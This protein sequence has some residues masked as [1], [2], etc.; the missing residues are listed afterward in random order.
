MQLEL[1]Q[2]YLSITTFPT[3]EVPQLTII[4]GLNGSG[5]SHLLEAIDRGAITND[6]IPPPFAF[7]WPQQNSE[8]LLIAN[9]QSPRSLRPNN[10]TNLN[11]YP[12]DNYELRRSI[13]LK[14]FTDKLEELSPGIL[15]ECVSR[16]DDVWRLGI[17]EV[18]HRTGVDI[19]DLTAVL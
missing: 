5:K 15:K 8:I 18:H 4:V 16:G 1:R 12:L 13:I 10:S 2:P 9:G 17:E 3:V 14:P 7:P 19:S 11:P 6:V